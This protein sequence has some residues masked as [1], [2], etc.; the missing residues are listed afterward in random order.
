[1]GEKSKSSKIPFVGARSLA[2]IRGDVSEE[3]STMVRCA[4]AFAASFERSPAGTRLH[5]IAKSARCSR[6]AVK[7]HLDAAQRLG[8]LRL[9]VRLPKYESLSKRLAEKYG[10]AEGVVTRTPTDWSNQESVRSALSAEAI[11]YFSD[12]CTKFG[13]ARGEG[14]R[15]RIGLDGGETLYR[16]VRG[17][18]GLTLPNLVYELVPLVFGPLKGPQFT[19]SIVAN[20]FAT[21]LEADGAEVVVQ[22]GFEIEADWKHLTPGQGQ[23]HFSIKMPSRE[24]VSGLD[25]LLLGIGSTTAGLLQR[26]MRHLSGVRRLSSNYFGDILNLAFDRDGREV[27]PIA[28]SRAVLLGLADLRL[29]SKSSTALVVGVAGGSAKV[30]AIR[31]VLR[32]GYISVLITDPFTA[33]KLLEA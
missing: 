31:T 3:D 14:S 26:E 1:M 18:G 33:T 2:P 12:F 20:V 17:A 5:E 24:N 11:H 30:E 19:A 27:G 10:L 4:R 6:N 15:M 9:T 29:L 8:L 13:E 23:V 25:L 21:A 28:R 16:A 7:A 32:S 22:D